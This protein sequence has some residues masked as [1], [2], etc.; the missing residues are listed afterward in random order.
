MTIRS[1]SH[2]RFPKET[3]YFNFDDQ[4]FTKGPELLIGRSIGS[5]CGYVEDVT[6]KGKG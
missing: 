3:Y 4:T 6:V 1:T 2:E 5:Q